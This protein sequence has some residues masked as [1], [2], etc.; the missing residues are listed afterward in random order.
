VDDPL[1]PKGLSQFVA[2]KVAEAKSNYDQSLLVKFQHLKSF[3]FKGHRLLTDR[4]KA[5]Q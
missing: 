2:L 5:K 1:Q 3:F 4:N